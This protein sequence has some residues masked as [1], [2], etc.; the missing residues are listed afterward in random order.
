M[1]FQDDASSI[2]SSNTDL[3]S[4]SHEPVKRGRKTKSKS[5]NNSKNV[6][7]QYKFSYVLNLNNQF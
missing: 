5:S 7:L 1:F 4:R 2:D 6:K 3:T